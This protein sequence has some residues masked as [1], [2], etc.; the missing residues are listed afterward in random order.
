MP[1]SDMSPVLR[2]V[3]HINKHVTYGC[4]TTAVCRMQSGMGLDGARRCDM[5]AVIVTRFAPVDD[6]AGQRLPFT[7]VSR[8]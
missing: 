3:S 6:A 7:V 2:C 1:R 5:S 8:E 4:E